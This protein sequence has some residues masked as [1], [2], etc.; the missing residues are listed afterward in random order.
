MPDNFPV[1]AEQI[2]RKRRRTPRS[3]Q[4]CRRCRTKCD[5]NQPCS[6]C[7]LA[8]TPC[9]YSGHPARGNNTTRG[10]V[11][12][13]QPTPPAGGFATAHD[14]NSRE[15]G[16]AALATSSD[17]ASE[18]EEE[19]ASLKRR[20][21]I[22]EELLTK[23]PPS[24]NSEVLRTPSSIVPE[25]AVACQTL[26]EGTLALNKCRLFGPSHWTNST[27]LEVSDEL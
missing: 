20:V 27:A 19:L 8:R 1:T 10:S 15:L 23:P 25:S 21:G 7:V 24:A 22:L 12:S 11:S 9:V 3:C 14:K 18:K 2:P 26:Q 5:R 13:Q 6:H 4:E 16:V 17:L